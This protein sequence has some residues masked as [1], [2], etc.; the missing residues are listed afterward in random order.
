MIK[1]APRQPRHRTRLPATFNPTIPALTY[2]AT[3]SAGNVLVTT[4]LPV[5]IAGLPAGF[6]VQGVSPLTITSVSATSFTLHYTAAVVSTNVFVTDANDP[7]VRG[8]AGG[9]LAAGSTTFP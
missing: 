2:T 9:Y 3:I 4:T 6:K 1:R 7:G 5:T 8:T